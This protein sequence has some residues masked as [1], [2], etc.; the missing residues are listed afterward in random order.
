[1]EE[2]MNRKNNLKEFCQKSQFSSCN[3]NCFRLYNELVRD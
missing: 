1:M 2:A 3:E